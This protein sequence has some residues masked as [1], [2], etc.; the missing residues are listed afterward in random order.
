MGAAVV[1]PGAEPYSLGEGTVGV[2]LVHGFTG[3]PS[4]TRPIGEWLASNGVAVEGVRLPGHG[5]GL[6]A[7]RRS[8]W[9]E[10]TNEASAGV[11]ALG[12]RCRTLVA[13]GLS[14]GASVV[15]HVAASRPH[16]VHGLALANPYVFDL[17]HLAVPIASRLLRGRNLRGVANDIAMPGQ[18]ENADERMP[19]PAIAEM[20]AMMRRVR[21]ELPE[22]HQPLA[23]FRSDVDH[24][25]P[26][27][28]VRRL[29]GRIGS[30]RSEVVA[31]P[32][33]F[34]VVTLDHDAP[35]VR[36]GV[37]AFARALDAERHPA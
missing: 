9:T 30:V 1:R 31:C 12:R 20:A 13:F 8:R 15:L 28:T 14:M 4:S 16:E 29:L 25:V 5:I 18:D 32:R 26:R 35:L 17:R 7:L 21:R 2:L 19:V 22:I 37:L 6:D 3:S 10:W 27:S 23:V 36:E 11:E 24:V 34:H 33:S